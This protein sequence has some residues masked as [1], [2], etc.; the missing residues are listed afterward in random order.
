MGMR[1]LKFDLLVSKARDNLPLFCHTKPIDFEDVCNACEDV[2]PHIP[3][4]IVD[5]AVSGGI[6]ESHM[7]YMAHHCQREYLKQIKWWVFSL[8]CRKIAFQIRCAEADRNGRFFYEY[9]F[10][11]YDNQDEKDGY[12]D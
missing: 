8:L 1:R 12:H 11:G 9:D 6:I 3:T 7:Q 4:E 5:L 2:L 10:V